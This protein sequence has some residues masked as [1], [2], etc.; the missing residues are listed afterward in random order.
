MRSSRPCN[1]EHRTEGTS[2]RSTEFDQI[3]FGLSWAVKQ[4]TNLQVLLLGDSGGPIIQRRKLDDK[5]L[6]ILGI[7]LS[8][9]T[10]ATLSNNASEIAKKSNKPDFIAALVPAYYD[11]ICK[12]TSE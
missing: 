5:S 11:F 8:G 2:A 9:S 1:F 12:A 10:N 4:N 3:S 7:V 6:C